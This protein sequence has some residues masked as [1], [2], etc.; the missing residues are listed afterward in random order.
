[1]RRHQPNTELPTWTFAA[2]NPDGAGCDASRSGAG[3]HPKVSWPGILCTVSELG[4]RSSRQASMDRG[5]ARISWIGSGQHRP[6]G[7]TLAVKPLGSDAR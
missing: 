7:G 6:T 1:M 4:D 5:S 2:Y 3:S